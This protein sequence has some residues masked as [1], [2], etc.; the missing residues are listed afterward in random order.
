M[1]YIYIEG[2]EIKGPLNIVSYKA[3]FVTPSMTV[4]SL[5]VAAQS[6]SDVIDS[7]GV[8]STP[9]GNCGYI[10]TYLTFVAYTFYFSNWLWMLSIYDNNSC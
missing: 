7:S 10:D 3:C 8:D 2:H 6:S 1:V 4:S 5:S 9:L